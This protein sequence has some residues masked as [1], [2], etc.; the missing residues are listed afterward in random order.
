MTGQ[1]E[2]CKLSIFFY[3]PSDNKINQI[4]VVKIIDLVLGLE[5]YFS[6]SKQDKLAKIEALYEKLKQK[7]M[8]TLF[9]NK[10]LKI[11]QKRRYK[12]LRLIIFC[13]A[14]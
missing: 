8:K 4:H 7:D 11:Q 14:L 6:I 3:Q 5:I 9:K 13:F 2:N 12:K 10:A 1:T